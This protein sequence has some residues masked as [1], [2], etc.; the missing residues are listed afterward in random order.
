MGPDEA[1]T[2]IEELRR[3]IAAHDRLYY[4]QA[5]PT[6]ADQD[7]DR[8][9]A[10]LADLEGSYPEQ[11]AGDSPTQ[12]VGDDRLPG[13]EHYRHRV[14]MQSLDNTYS[15][16]ELRAFHE[17][18]VKVLGREDLRYL[19]EP[20]ID[21]VAVSLTYEDGILVRAVTRG[22]GVEGDDVTENIRLIR[23]LPGR[24]PGSGFPPIIEIRGEIFMTNEEFRRI[25]Q[26]REE[27]GLEVYANPRNLTS[28]T[29]KLLDRREVAA[30]QLDI[31]LYGLGYHEGFR[32]ETQG[33]FHRLLGEWG[34][35]TVEMKW[36]ADGMD[37]VWAAI[38]ELD[39]R[40]AD[41]AYA[42]DGAVIK[43]DSVAAQQE[44]GSTSKAPRWAIAYKF[45]AERAETILRAISIQVGRTGVL[46]PVAELE[47][48]QLAGTTVSR[49]TLHNAE[50]IARKDVR[51]GDT[52]SVEKAGE[53]IPAVIAVNLQKRPAGSVPYVFPKACPVC[54][55][56][57]VRLEG[58]VAQRCPNPNCPAQVRRR[59]GHFASKGCLD[60]DGMGIAVVDQL[61][62]RGLVTRLPDLYRLDRESL[63][64][65]EKF[66][67]KSAD[68][69]LAAIEASKTAELWRVIHGLG[70]PH[71]GATTARDLARA[72]P[73]LETLAAAEEN[74]L[75][76]VEG[77]GSVL[78]AAIRT[79]FEQE[80]NRDLLRE[81]KE[82]GFEPTGPGE[83]VGAGGSLA[84]KTFVLTGTL[85]SMT[86]DEARALIEGAGGKVTSGVSRKT[87]YVVAGEE[88]GSKL[89]QAEKL[90]VS[91]IDEAGLRGLIERPA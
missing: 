76:A 78:A 65:L 20:K 29:V 15:E 3:E 31:V 1:R 2:R 54:R 11:A 74:A 58:E 73:S 49:A 6:I 42:T 26:L 18:L 89:A 59:L 63:L 60:I 47:P 39:S 86:R 53:I 56:P 38:Q 90:G 27:D 80:A 33:D 16:E 9:K 79:Y 8:L 17:R 57:T 12:R 51:E 84:G 48:V 44:V 91:V 41:F 36:S 35:P 68:N 66:A 72:F 83:G 70:I 71:V 46:T 43:L 22:N 69:L 62:T 23:S 77:I 81:L 75:V 55:T 82:L 40:R 50:E 25:N 52:V 67:A 14:P 13:F 85:P 10:E 28:G 21:G 7:Y 88:A 64:G 87:D 4:Q 30:R 34:L 24:L 45:A 5:A 19:V 61:V 32:I 37:A